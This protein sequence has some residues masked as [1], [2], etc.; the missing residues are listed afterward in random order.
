[1][2]RRDPDIQVG[3]EPQF[4]SSQTFKC[5]H[6]F[7]QVLK[8]CYTFV[9]KLIAQVKLNPTKQQAKLLKQTIEQ[10]NATCD[11]ISELAFNSQTFGQYAIHQAYYAHIRERSGLSA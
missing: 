3:E 9:V 5:Y 7:V 6:S 1:M 10:A 11:A 4:E 2:R 8:M